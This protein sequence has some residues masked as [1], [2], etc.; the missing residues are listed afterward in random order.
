[1]HNTGQDKFNLKNKEIC[2]F[3]LLINELNIKL[4]TL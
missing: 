2:I 1:M 4:N 3:V